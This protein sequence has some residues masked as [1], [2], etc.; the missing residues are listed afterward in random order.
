MMTTKV[1]VS[2]SAAYVPT[3]HARA[4][5]TIRRVGHVSIVTGA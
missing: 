1:G 5:F 2:R 3:R 4:F